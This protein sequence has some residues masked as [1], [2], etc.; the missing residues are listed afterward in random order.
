MKR[1]RSQTN[2]PKFLIRQAAEINMTDKLSA[3]CLI[4]AVQHFNILI[5]NGAQVNAQDNNGNT[6]LHHAI[7]DKNIDQMNFL[8]ING[9]DSNIQK[10]DLLQLASLNGEEGIAKEL[11]EQQ[12]PAFLLFTIS[13]LTLTTQIAKLWLK[14]CWN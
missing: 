1:A 2:T 5:E 11:M 6:A 10:H 8:L 14:T 12:E 9:S 4:T 7:M 13:Q 3:T